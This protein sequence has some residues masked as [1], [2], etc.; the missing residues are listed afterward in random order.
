MQLLIN[1][2]HKTKVFDLDNSLTISDLKNIIDDL[3]YIPPEIQYLTNGNRLLTTGTLEDNQLKE[4]SQI[5]LNL[6][7]LGGTRYKKSSSQ[8]RWK[9]RKK[10]M[11]RLQRQ[12]RRMRNRAK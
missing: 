5:N 4:G 3:E 10:R 9:W 11:K 12:R 2:L 1:L 7:V 8:M 6:K